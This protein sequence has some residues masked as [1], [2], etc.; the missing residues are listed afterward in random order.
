[1]ND[2]TRSRRLYDRA[3]KL[4]PWGTQTGSKRWAE[5]LRD[6]LPAFIA[7]GKGCRVWDVDGNEYID[8]RCAFGPIILGYADRE[9]N[10]AVKKQIDLGTLYGMAHPVEIELAELVNELVPCAERVRFFKT[11]ADANAAAVRVARTFT[12]KEKVISIGYHGWIDT[13][14]AKTTKVPG[15]P[16]VDRQLMFDVRP[17]DLDAIKDVVSTHKN[18]VA[19]LIIDLACCRD[20][21]R[22]YLEA[23]RELTSESN[24]LLS[25]DEI[26]TGFRYSLGGAQSYFG[27]TPDLAAFGK[28]MANGYA[29]SALCGKA[30][31][32]DRAFEKTTIS[33]TYYGD[34]STIAASIA[35]ISKLRRE[36]VPEMLW[37]RGERL[38]TF[39]NEAARKAR[40]GIKA[41]GPACIFDVASGNPQETELFVKKFLEKGVMPGSPYWFMQYSHSDNELDK[42]CEIIAE[43]LGEVRNEL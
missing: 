38:K 42:T 10:A 19:I 8:F 25:F 33:G 1:M 30:E 4:I 41:S 13:L 11:G 28:A 22:E 16:G 29:I 2:L 26:I 9:V 5:A 27:I 32:M 12:G 37:S 40:L 17:N 3:I 15:I 6:H 39:I 14:L 36:G 35:T 21:D 24:I 43:A 23:I 18:E 31:I 34:T 20:V 7:R